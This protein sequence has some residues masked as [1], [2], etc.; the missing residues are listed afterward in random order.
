MPPAKKRNEFIFVVDLASDETFLQNALDRIFTLKS[1]ETRGPKKDKTNDQFQLIAMN[2][3]HPDT[4]GSNYM[5][6]SDFATPMYTDGVFKFLSEHLLIYKEMDYKDC[7]CNLISAIQYGGGMFNA[8]SDKL[9]VSTFFLIVISDFK[10]FPNSPYDETEIQ[11]CV[12][13]ICTLN[14]K[15]I[16][17]VDQ[18]ISYT[19]NDM[20][21]TC[22][23][24]GKVMESIQIPRRNSAIEA[25]CSIAQ[26]TNGIVTGEKLFLNFVTFFAN[27]V[28]KQPWN[29]SLTLGS[30]SYSTVTT[31]LTEQANSF[32]GKRLPIRQ[33]AYR[34]PQTVNLQDV[35]ILA[36]TSS[37]AGQ[38]IAEGDVALVKLFH[39]HALNIPADVRA[40]AKD[41]P[42]TFKILGFIDASEMSELYYGGDE[43]FAV[44]A[45][46]DNP[47]AEHFVELVFKM[48]RRKKY[49]IAARVYSRGKSASAFVLIPQPEG[50]LL[51][52][53]LC[54]G[55]LR[56]LNPIEVDHTYVD[57]ESLSEGMLALRHHLIKNNALFHPCSSLGTGQIR[58]CNNVRRLCGYNKHLF[59]PDEL[60]VGLS[61]RDKD[62]INNMFVPTSSKTDKPAVEE[63]HQTNDMEEDW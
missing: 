21:E 63:P 59:K 23:E 3:P 25:V 54:E 2:Y 49:A 32:L 4:D 5:L 47:R 12:D 34:Q 16:A 45:R 53:H 11:Q 28:S 10:N 14:I 22:R 15:F 36:T 51:M 44:N 52:T 37:D 39:G 41:V 20:I 8:L 27:P 60:T 58:V 29:T 56:V 1:L 50:W 40:F 31:K 38:Q 55:A 9:H 48:I 18:D 43:S 42:A 26:Q 13:L 33:S 6:I 17:V 46:E 35:D 61:H 57:E 19:Y 62:L 7:D 24:V 30:Y